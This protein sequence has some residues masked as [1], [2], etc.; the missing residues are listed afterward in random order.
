MSK[1]RTRI[2]KI[3]TVIVPVSDQERAIAFYVDALGL[4]K[5]ADVPFGDGNR[6]VEVGRPAPPARSR[7]SRHRPA[8]PLA[9][10]RQASPCTATTST[11]C[12]PSSRRAASTSTPRSAAWATRSRR[13]SGS[14]I[15]TATR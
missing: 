15:P 5:R 13:C 9:T 14:A 10:S 8:S 3:G 4:E 2:E 11:P 12:T 1:T 7:S 6:W